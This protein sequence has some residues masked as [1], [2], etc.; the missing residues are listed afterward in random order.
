MEDFDIFSPK[1]TRVVKGVEGK[2]MLV[3]SDSVKCGK[4]TVGSEMPKPFYLIF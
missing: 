1:K 3:H 2:L 4:N